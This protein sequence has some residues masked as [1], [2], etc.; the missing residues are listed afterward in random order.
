[1]ILIAALV[2][3]QVAVVGWSA[4]SAANAARAGARAQL[5]GSEVEEAALAALP[6]ALSGRATV[7]TG[8]R[9]VQV[10][11]RAPKLLPLGPA[12]EV[13]SGAALDPSGGG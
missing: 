3:V 13:G 12:F 7:T 2:L 11:V 8:E 10:E 5:V 6:A 9:L 1:M 4:W